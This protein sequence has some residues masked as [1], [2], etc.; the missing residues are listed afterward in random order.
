MDPF[1][2]NAQVIWALYC[3][4]MAVVVAVLLLADLAAD[5]PDELKRGSRGAQ[6]WRQK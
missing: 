2:G 5:H 6:K 3:I 4:G 1:A